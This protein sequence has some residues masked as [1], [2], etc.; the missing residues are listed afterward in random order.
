MQN[1]YELYV[2]EGSKSCILTNRLSED[3]VELPVPDGTETSA[4]I[5]V[6]KYLAGGGR[7]SNQSNLRARLRMEGR[8]GFLVLPRRTRVLWVEG[9]GPPFLFIYD[10]RLVLRYFHLYA[11]RDFRNIIFRFGLQHFFDT[12][13]D[14]CAAGS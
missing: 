5:E 6:G 3:R 10:S 1:D 8:S 11:P 7:D 12:S 2:K 4:M 9:F 14:R 13:G